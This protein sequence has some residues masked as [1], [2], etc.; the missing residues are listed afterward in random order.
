[1]VESKRRRVLNADG[2]LTASIDGGEGT[3][4]ISFAF[5]PMKK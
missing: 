5:Q 1:M 2:S 4:S 3:R